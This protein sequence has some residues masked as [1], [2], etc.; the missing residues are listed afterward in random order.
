[1]G[2][3]TSQ[4]KEWLSAETLAKITERQEKK[5]VLNIAKIRGVKVQRQVKFTDTNKAVKNSVRRD[6][7]NFIERLVQEAEDAAS[8]G[9]MKE[10]YHI[11]KKTLWVHKKDG[12]L[13]TSESEQLNRWREH[14][15]ELMNRPPPTTITAIQQNH[16]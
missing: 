5:G 3:R 14:F 11:T 2:K 1:M 10:V 6:K 9:V 12:K 4:H 16:P 7:R 15:A 8:K 13:L